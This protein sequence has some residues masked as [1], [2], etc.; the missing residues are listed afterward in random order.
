MDNDDVSNF[1]KIGHKYD[2]DMTNIV[3]KYSQTYKCMHMI[4]AQYEWH[5]DKVIWN[6]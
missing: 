4:Y 6:I 2:E 1:K 3:Y 5:M